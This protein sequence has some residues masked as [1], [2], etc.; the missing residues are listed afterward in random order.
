MEDEYKS[1]K[2]YDKF[3]HLF[4]WR[5]RKKILEIVIRNKYKT[6]LDVC[7]GTGNQLK[8]LKKH[9]IDG[10]GVDLS[11]TMLNIAKTG[12]LKVDCQEQDAE[13]INFNDESF[14]MTMTTFALHEKSN[15]SAKKIINEMIRLT[16]KNGHLIIVDFSIDDR[17]SFVSRKGIKFIESRA[18]DDHYKHYKEYIAYSGLNHLLDRLPLKEIEKHYFALNGVVLKLLQKVK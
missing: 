5:I 6:I 9:G 12:K 16:K 1:A 3:L 18:G 10:T 14:D 4:V 8:L 11:T 7:C 15:S 2:Y 17:T 13:N